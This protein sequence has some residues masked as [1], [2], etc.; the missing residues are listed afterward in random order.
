MN[1]ATEAT[2]WLHCDQMFFPNQKML[3]YCIESGR[4]MD[5]DAWRL[6]NGS[7][8]EVSAVRTLQSQV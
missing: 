1:D 2:E 3:K 7:S 8:N 4:K 5:G 6:S